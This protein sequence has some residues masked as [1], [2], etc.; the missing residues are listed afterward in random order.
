MKTVRAYAKINLGLRIHGKRADGYHEIETVLHRIDLYDEL[1]FESSTSLEMCSSDPAVPDGKDN[2]CLR[3][4]SLLRKHLNISAGARI[5]LTKRIPIGAGLGGGRADAGTVLRELPKF[6]N[7]SPDRDRL[8][9][10]ALE[11]GSDVPYFLRNG[12]AIARG[13]GELLEYFPLSLPYTVLL[14]YPRIQVSTAWAYSQVKPIPKEHA[15]NLKDLLIDGLRNPAELSRNLKNDF[16]SIVF[17]TFPQLRNIKDVMLHEGAIYAS[18]SG[19]GSSVFGL[20]SD[21]SGVR[22][23]SRLLQS[24]NYEV[25]LSPPH[26][27]PGD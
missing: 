9:V 24:R 16:E 17:D 13:R 14:C 7:V 8:S 4:T 18:L 23:V 20:F 12:T 26:F 6:W 19:S 22:T 5:S 21:L 11:L 27:S 25:F 15:S 1:H 3:A 2:L 10:L